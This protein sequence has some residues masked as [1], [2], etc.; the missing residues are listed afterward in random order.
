MWQRDDGELK[1][2][3]ADHQRPVDQ[4]EDLLGYS[5]IGATV[6]VGVALAIIFAAF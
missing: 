1:V 4:A 6:A 5:L 3:F 2:S